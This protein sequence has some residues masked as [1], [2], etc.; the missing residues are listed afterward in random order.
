METLY[1]IIALGSEASR[2]RGERNAPPS[3]QRKRAPKLYE[4]HA[5]LWHGYCAARMIARAS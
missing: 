1:I 3:F 2:V 4:D 5:L